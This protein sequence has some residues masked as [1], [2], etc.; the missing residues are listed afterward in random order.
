MADRKSTAKTVEPKIAL[1][2]TDHIAQQGFQKY[3]AGV[4]EA[5]RE[6]HRARQEETPGPA[7][8]APKLNNG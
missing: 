1:T 4:A 2:V 3:V 8:P 6:K 7:K 5:F